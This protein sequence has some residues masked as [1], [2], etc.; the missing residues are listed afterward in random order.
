MLAGS[1]RLEGFEKIRQTY[2]R[3][4]VDRDG[5]E[6]WFSRDPLE[7]AERFGGQWLSADVK[8][9]D[10]IIFGMHLMHASTTNLTNRFRLSCDVRFQ[11]A[12]EP[13]DARWRKHGTG[14]REQ[15]QVRPI[16]DLK[17]EWGLL[18]SDA[19]S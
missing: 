8:A 14:H 16:E 10:A 13:M 1:H 5:V 17:A 19:K 18:T 4:D 2:G 15:A 12:S 9:G 11:P 3:M 6:G 7:L